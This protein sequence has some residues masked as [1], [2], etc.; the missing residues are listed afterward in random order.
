MQDRFD[1]AD[2][3]EEKKRMRKLVK[4]STA[5]APA[6][7]LGGGESRTGPKRKKDDPDSDSD[8]DEDDKPASLTGPLLS[9][10]RWPRDAPTFE[11]DVAAEGWEMSSSCVFF[12]FSSSHVTFLSLFLVPPC[13]YLLRSP[14]LL[15]WASATGY[16][17]VQETFIFAR[18]RAKK[19]PRIR[20]E[21]IILITLNSL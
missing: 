13:L 8:S 19:G 10:A 21:N 17:G 1:K 16:A 9:L 11:N 4:K 14:L 20:V 6:E 7:A 15:C 3:E 2:R 5:Q 18:N 12:L